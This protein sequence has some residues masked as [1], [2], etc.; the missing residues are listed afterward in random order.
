MNQNNDLITLINQEKLNKYNFNQINTLKFY[1]HYIPKILIESY[2]KLKNIDNLDLGQS[3]LTGSNT[4]DHIF[5]ILMTYTC[6]LQPTV[7]LVDRAILLY[8]KF[9]IMSRNPDM[10]N[11]PFYLPNINDAQLFV[12]KKSIGPISPS[13][14]ISFKDLEKT[15]NATYLIKTILESVFLVLIKVKNLSESKEYLEKYLES[16][17]SHITT[18]IFNLYQKLDIY[19]NN[20]Y[21]IIIILLGKLDQTNLL[22]IIEF[23]RILTICAIKDHQKLRDNLDNI[24]NKYLDHKSI[25]LDLSK[26]KRETKLEKEILSLLI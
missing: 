19:D 21:Q 23:I 8:I 20:F 25:D 26:L 7:F 16:I 15:K 5:W 17:L 13:N 14:L 22:W 10:N 11:D 3:I 12:Y 6:N 4:I 9:I 1:C 2:Y 18:P 24:I